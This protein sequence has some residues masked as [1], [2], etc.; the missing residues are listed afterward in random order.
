VR[1]VYLDYAATTPVRPEVIEAMLPYFSDTI[2][3]ASSL[4]M[5]GQSAK[6]ALE[7][8]RQIVAAALGADSVE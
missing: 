3:N 5:F 4:H 7:E 8:A 6:R 2:G 1:R